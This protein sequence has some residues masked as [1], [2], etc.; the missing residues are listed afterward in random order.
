MSNYTP[1]K[2][3]R[4]LFFVFILIFILLIHYMLDGLMIK[5]T[6]KSSID[7]A[8][9][10]FKQFIYLGIIY[11]CIRFFIVN[12]K[13]FKD[14]FKLDRQHKIRDIFQIICIFIIFFIFYGPFIIGLIQGILQNINF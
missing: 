2:F 3:R 6:I 10:F 5:G 13:H 1:F 12:I 9:L 11:Y 4:Q 8:I 7:I 14:F